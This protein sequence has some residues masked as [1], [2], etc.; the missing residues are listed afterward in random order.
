[1]TMREIA[2]LARLNQYTAEYMALE[3]EK[4]LYYMQHIKDKSRT[5]ITTLYLMQTNIDTVIKQIC[6][7]V[8]RLDRNG[9]DY[10]NE[11]ATILFNQYDSYIRR[12][13]FDLI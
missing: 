11:V 12:G 2:M 3:R 6:M 9:I 5:A 8:R 13:L 4:D 1:M 7:L 10:D